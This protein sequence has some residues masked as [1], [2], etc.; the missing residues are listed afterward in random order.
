MNRWVRFYS[1]GALGIIVQL[2]CIA[3]LRSIGVHYLIST[4]ISVEAAVLHNFLWHQAW[5]WKDRDGHVF[6]RFVSFHLANGFLS[7]AGNLLFMPLFVEI[8]HLPLLVANLIAIAACS[9]LNFLAA[10]RVVFRRACSSDFSR[11]RF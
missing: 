11:W 4:A 3:F 10:D 2:C 6:A 1:V 5:T 8:A 9:V 7:V